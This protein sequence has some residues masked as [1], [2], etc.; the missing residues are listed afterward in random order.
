MRCVGI[1]SRWRTTFLIEN[2]IEY[3]VV[4]FDDQEKSAKLSLRQTEILT[5]LNDIV[6]DISAGCPIEYVTRSTL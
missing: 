5:K 6:H 3:M 1:R 2:K 4:A